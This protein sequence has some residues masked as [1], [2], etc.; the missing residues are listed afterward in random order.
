MGRIAEVRPRWSKVQLLIDPGSQVNGMIQVS[1]ATGL[2]TGQPDGSLV[3]EQIPQAEQ[4]NVGDTVVTSGRSGGGG[5]IP[6]GLIV[7]Q[8]AAVEKKDID[9]YQRA[10]LRPA[11]DMS[12]LEMVMVITDFEP[13]P[14]DEAP[15]EAVP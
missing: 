3:L 4:L 12:R 7:G 1:R 2:V 14:L 11:A 15:D 8:V 13:V 10:I 6:K 9:L 5:L